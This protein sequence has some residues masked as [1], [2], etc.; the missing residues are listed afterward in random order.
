MAI[1]LAAITAFLTSPAGIQAVTV[2]STVVTATATLVQAADLLDKASE[3]FEF[4][5]I[6][7]LDNLAKHAQGIAQAYTSMTLQAI[8]AAEQTGIAA[9]RLGMS[10]QTFSE[11]REHVSGSGVSV[12][13]LSKALSNFSSNIAATSTGSSK[14]AEALEVMGIKATDAKGHIKNQST[15]LQEV[16]G[17]MSTY[18]DGAEKSA[19]ATALFGDQAGAMLPVLNQGAAGFE[20]SQ[21]KARLFGLTISDEFAQHSAVFNQAMGDLKSLSTGFA[22]QLASAVVP[23]LGALANMF[24]STAEEALEARGGMENLVKNNLVEWARAGG[25]AL[26]GLVDIFNN[27]WTVIQ[28]FSKSLAIAYVELQNLAQIHDLSSVF[29]VLNPAKAFAN[30]EEIASIIKS[31]LAQASAYRKDIDKLLMEPVDK[32]QQKFQKSFDNVFKAPSQGIQQTKDAPSLNRQ[33]VNQALADYMGPPT[34]TTTRSDIK[35]PISGESDYTRYLRQ[36]REKNA[37]GEAELS[38][39]KSLT[40]IEKLQIELTGKF[41]KELSNLQGKKRADL[42]LELDKAIAL[43]KSKQAHEKITQELAEIAQ[44]YKEQ[45]DQLSENNKKTW[46]EIEL[47]GKSAAEIEAAADAKKRLAFENKGYLEVQKQSLLALLAEGNA[48]QKVKSAITANAEAEDQLAKM[49]L[50][51]IV[52]PEERARVELEQ[53]I[54]KQRAKVDSARQAYEELEAIHRDHLARLEVDEVA[55]SEALLK[56]QKE[57]AESAKAVAETLAKNSEEIYQRLKAKPM[58]EDLHQTFQTIDG[59]AKDIFVNIFNGG[60]DVFSKL[61]D[62]L[63]TTLIDA[64]YKMTVK[65][66]I[67]NIE[68]SYADVLKNGGGFFDWIGGI[69]KGDSENSDGG[70]RITGAATSWGV[71]KAADGALSTTSNST[72][73]WG[74]AGMVAAFVILGS[75]LI[76]AVSGK[77][78]PKIGAS[79]DYDLTSGNITRQYS[80]AAPFVP[81]DIFDP[82]T[83]H[84]V[85]QTTTDYMDDVRAKNKIFENLLDTATKGFTDVASS[86]GIAVGG[87]SLTA[88]MELDPAGDAAGHYDVSLQRDG[89][90]LFSRI[91]ET[92]HDDIQAVAEGLPK[93]YVQALAAAA[94]DSDVSPAVGALIDEIGK[95]TEK[96]IEQMLVSIQQLPGLIS[97]ITDISGSADW[98]NETSLKA[99]GG[100]DGLNTALATLAENVPV[101][102]RVLIDQ[103]QAEKDA[104]QAFKALNMAAPKTVDELLSLMRGMDAT[105]D[106]TGEMRAKML[107]LSP[108]VIKAAK[109]AE[110]TVQ[111]YTGWDS[112]STGKALLDAVFSASNAEEA[113]QKFSDAFQQSFVQT[114]AGIITQQVGQMVFD[115]IITPMIQS[116]LA[117]TGVLQ[118]GAATAGAAM[119]TGG[120]ISGEKLAG[121]VGEIKKYLTAMSTVLSDPAIKDMLKE[122]TGSMG[123]VGSMT[124]NVVS[125]IPGYKAPTNTG[126]S[127]GDNTNDSVSTNDAEDAAKRLKD[128]IAAFA[129]Q[130]RLAAQELANLDLAPISRQVAELEQELQGQFQQMLQDTAQAL[131]V[132]ATL[133]DVAKEFGITLDKTGDP[134]QQLL[135]S[136]NDLA[137][138]AALAAIAVGDLANRKIHDLV[139][140][141]GRDAWSQWLEVSGGDG[142]GFSR[143]VARGKLDDQI[144]VLNKLFDTNAINIGNLETLG[145]QYWSTMSD[146]QRAAAIDALNYKNEYISAIK[147]QFDQQ[148]QIV[149]DW[150]SKLA[151]V[152]A[153][154]KTLSEDIAGIQITAGQLDKGTYL[155]DREA[156]IRAQFSQN[157]ADGTFS[158]TT[159][160]DEQLSLAQELRQVILDQYQVQIE[161]ATKLKEFARNLR[162][163]VNSLKVGELSP[164]TMKQ[165]LDEAE[166]QYRRT[167]AAARG[168]DE[169]AR[170]QLTGKA[171]TYLKLSQEYYAKTGAQNFAN[172]DQVVGELS[173]LGIESED[174]ATRQLTLTGD[175]V[176]NTEETVRKLRDLESGVGRVST[177]ISGELSG[178]VSSLQQLGTE[179]STFGAGGV[180]TT[181]IKDL[182][183]AIAAMVNSPHST[184]TTTTPAVN[185]PTHWNPEV[186]ADIIRNVV[187]SGQYNIAQIAELANQ[188]GVG[189]G[190]IGAAYGLSAE[191]IMQIARDNNV[192]LNAYASGG[193]VDGPEL[194]LVGEGGVPE[195]IIPMPY[196]DI[197]VRLLGNG[198]AALLDE[199]RALRQEVTAL[200][201]Q[202]RGETEDHLRMQMEVAQRL[203]EATQKAARQTERAVLQAK[204]TVLQ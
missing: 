42:Q 28:I 202:Q 162:D 65:K 30:K 172:F 9:Q 101:H 164:W 166:T 134:L 86:L 201:A 71:G 13:E 21:A 189:A 61:R 132:P 97:R 69:F 66:W 135:A 191:D 103:A 87:L 22:N 150:A 33:A 83:G 128:Q 158:A 147:Q 131:D 26:A 62:T 144:G 104:T 48:L 5:S 173:A 49:R 129:E 115:S 44:S 78:G 92:A 72:S 74:A 75:Q 112:A 125:G 67:L 185:P 1:P 123:S 11:W 143:D 157:Y 58:L 105:T 154:A 152:Q 159:R 70:S 141:A 41:G 187:G 124:Y 142:A 130:A 193:I 38:T 64:L 2:A 56:L 73:A 100:L 51:A 35:P 15:L 46:E 29:G 119:A 149:Q 88:G 23:V 127:S 107:A 153:F 76:E 60:K 54:A 109:A 84:L 34:L 102:R 133:Q 121:A 137:K 77:G 192:T 94:R 98:V 40:E 111:A 37:L 161:G 200:R 203:A 8:N 175:I 47:F 195:A 110:A 90:V 199:M 52:D 186:S 59:L 122:L 204:E 63:K 12:D 93:L 17:V 160:L 108:A 32:Y 165:R 188:Y 170:G 167:L 16:A 25:S 106:A 24:A 190:Q 181:A 176:S 57:K 10:T 20:K 7:Y 194:A 14:A 184:T 139:L 156:A 183:A 145:K 163:Y 146:S 168:G 19:L 55:S 39:G 196:G 179:L 79:R 50:D 99:V 3:K 89:A 114:I 151:N 177:A 6:H 155:R 169:A 96:S 171:D 148:L 116:T 117:Q 178:A 113:G 95:S 45:S 91:V 4:S 81:Q 36:L 43:E 198:D 27:A 31:G 138:G 118:S 197:P 53:Q 180:F 120:A 126:N 18:K 174:T 136:T 80:T 82:E 85:G 140:Q 68:S 182:T